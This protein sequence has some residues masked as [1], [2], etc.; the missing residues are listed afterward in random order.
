M[1]DGNPTARRRQ[2]AAGMRRRLLAH[3]AAGGTTD[4]AAAAMTNDRNVYIDPARAE[5][6]KDR[7]FRALP[8]V[9]GLSCDVAEPGDCLLFEAVGASAAIVRG[10]DG[11]LRGFLNMCV[12]RGARLLGP[13]ETGRCSRHRQLV[14][15]FHGWAYDLHGR[16]VGVP[17]RAGFDDAVLAGRRLVSVAVAERHGLVF[18]QLR[19]AT[20]DV[21]RHLGD[22][23]AQLVDIEFEDLAPIRHSRLQAATDWKLAM[24][25]YCEGY[26]FGVLHRD[27]IGDA[28]HSNVAIFDAYGPHWR[29]G[30]AE[31]TLDPL[32]DRPEGAWPVPAFNAVYCLFPN[33]VVVAGELEGGNACLRMFRLFPGARPGTMSC[34]IAA[35][36]TRSV[37]DDNTLVERY[38]AQDDAESPITHEDYAMAEA[39][40]A[41]ALA[42]PDGFRFVYGQN[43]P[44]LQWFHRAVAER[45]GE[46]PP[47]QSS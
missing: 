32:L 19:G 31:R 16:L 4:C 43:E 35:Y 27:S 15:P 12:H 11:E 10:D 24:D 20:I 37:A 41:N 33:V 6:E 21:D 7:L 45:M 30:F 8:L 46:T 9:A 44:A 2:T 34:H 26:H 28:Y 23:A 17:G 40:Y 42:A 22:L 36:A 1:D 39:A 47:G 25:T 5:R 18:V 29:L 13:N 3:L 14:C 38:F